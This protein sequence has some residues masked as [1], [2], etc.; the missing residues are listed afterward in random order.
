MATLSRWSPQHSYAY[1][2]GNP[3]SRIDPL[4]LWEWPSLPQSVVNAP[5][6]LGDALLL[7][8][9]ARL[10]RLLNIDS[11]DTCSRS[12][13]GGQLA[14]IIGTLVTGEGVA[15]IPGRPRAHHT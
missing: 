13:Q 11:V 10:R 3:I 4:G 15:T 2:R 1:V 14:G 7:N 12:Y 9:G 5:A 6:G 8:Q